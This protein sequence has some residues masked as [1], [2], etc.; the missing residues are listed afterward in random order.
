MLALWGCPLLQCLQH[1]PASC[2]HPHRR[3]YLGCH[4]LG[5]CPPFLMLSVRSL[6]VATFPEILLPSPHGGSPSPSTP[7]RLLVEP[8]RRRLPHWR[9]STVCTSGGLSNCFMERAPSWAVAP[10]LQLL[11]TEL[12]AGRACCGGC[13]RPHTGVASCRL[14][15]ATALGG[16]F[17]LDFCQQRIDSGSIYAANPFLIDAHDKEG[18][19]GDTCNCSTLGAGARKNSSLSLMGGNLVRSCLSIF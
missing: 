6:G 8:P 3:W 18:L 5:C 1:G 19:V 2:P 7:C 12:R 17:C 10:L 13:C 16:F 15:E 4:H 9:P 14:R 11:L